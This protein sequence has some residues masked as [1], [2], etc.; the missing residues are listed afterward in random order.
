LPSSWSRPARH[1]RTSSQPPPTP[2]CDATDASAGRDIT[3]VGLAYDRRRGELVGAFRLRGEPSHES[4]AFVSLFAGTRT[5]SGCNGF[6]AAGFGSFSD[7]F[8]A[9][10]LRLD[11]AAGNGPSGDA[12][13]RGTS[14][15]SR[16]SRSATGSWPVAAWTA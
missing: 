10:W 9:S 1:K 3:A 14:P 16:S 5:P 12:D 8:G 2:P 15:T 11:D 13:K 6:P 4:S 7:E